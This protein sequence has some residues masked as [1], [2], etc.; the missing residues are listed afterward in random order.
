MALGV[1]IVLLFT[2]HGF[3]LSF[4]TAKARN[5]LTV[6]FVSSLLFYLFI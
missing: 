4:L 1:N 3:T 5:N 6:F 2:S